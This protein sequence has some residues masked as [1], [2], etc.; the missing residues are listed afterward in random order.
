MPFLVRANKVSLCVTMA[1][2]FCMVSVYDDCESGCEVL[3]VLS[4]YVILSMIHSNY[5][6][7]EY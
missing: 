6:D 4:I 5:I 2:L 1:G 7:L 3:R